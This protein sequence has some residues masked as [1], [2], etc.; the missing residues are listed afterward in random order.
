MSGKT[1]PPSIPHSGPLIS[2][3]DIVGR[4]PVILAGVAGIT[5]T[6]VMLGF[7]KTFAGVLIARGLAGMASGNGPVVTTVACEIT[8][9]TNQVYAF[10]FLGIWWPFG[11]IL[12]CVYLRCT[13][14]SNF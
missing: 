14:S 11:L 7:S 5:I 9:D 6:T 12:G 4:R 3:L 10:P 1:F 8:D 13:T 2:G